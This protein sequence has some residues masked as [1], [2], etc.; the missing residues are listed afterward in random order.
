MVRLPISLA[1]EITQRLKG[2]VS[3]DDVVQDLAPR[4]G[5]KLTIVQAIAQVMRKAK[6]PLTVTEIYNRIIENELYEFKAEEPV[7]VVRSQIRRHCEGLD[8]KS[9]LPDKYF[10]LVDENKYWLKDTL[11]AEET[12]EEK[13]LRLSKEDL[14]QA[15]KIKYENYLVDLKKAALAQVKNLSSYEFEL[16][17]KGVLVAFGFQ[18]IEITDRTDQGIRGYG[19]CELQYAFQIRRSEE[20]IQPSEIYEF[21]GSIDGEFRQGKFFTT[22]DFTEKAREAA[23]KPGAIPIVLVD[24]FH[25]IERMIDQNSEPDK[26][27]LEEVRS[28]IYGIRKEIEE[29]RNV[30]TKL[31]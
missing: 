5:T 19:D 18:N 4:T 21:R 29:V 11:S 2:E 26:E 30:I 24:G 13:N 31:L 27:D 9:A 6:K 22:S 20:P 7:Q 14:I 8:F 16:F 17:N 10:V 3:V 15:F 28:V 12:E 25:M 23:R 1:D